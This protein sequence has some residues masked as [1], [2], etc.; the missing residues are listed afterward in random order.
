[1]SLFARARSV[2]DEQ[3]S[4]VRL[5]G[6]VFQDGYRQGSGVLVTQESAMRSSAVWACVRLL[7]GTGSMLPVDVVR[8]IGNGQRQ[9]VNPTP[10]IVARPS[11]L[12]ADGNLYARVTETSADMRYIVRA[13]ILDPTS[14]KWL[15]RDGVLRPHI[16]GLAQDLWPIGDLWHVPAYLVP[17]SPVGLSP[18]EYAAESIGLNLAA[19]KFGAEFFGDGGHP[20]AIL[21]PASDPGP[22]GAKAI[23]A[24]WLS[25]TRGNREP[26]VLPQTIKYERIQVNPEESQ[27]LDSQRFSIEDICRFFG[28]PPE[29]IGAASSGSSVTYANREQ[30]AV[31]FLTFGLDPW[32]TRLEEMLTEQ[33]PRPQV[34]KINRAAILRSDTMTRYQAHEIALR[35]RFRSV[36]EVRQLEDEE[37]IGP[38]GDFPDS[39]EGAP[40]E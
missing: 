33:M 17:G 22:E 3:R 18:V 14:V 15:S 30:R 27:F 38:T 4:T 28:V 24:S 19:R 21:A 35:N 7:A 25:A 1:V 11:L 34:A 13:E 37:P 5:P 36:N 2:P 26:A 16:N 20:S 10:T 12:V 9:A 39:D 8:Y 6:Y 31:D 29:M 23:K 32:L 40:S